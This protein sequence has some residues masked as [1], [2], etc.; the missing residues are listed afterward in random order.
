MTVLKQL[1]FLQDLRYLL[2]SWS[3]SQ[4]R[5]HAE[6]LLPVSG[7]GR[8]GGE[9]RGERCQRGPGR[10]VPQRAEERGAREGR[11]ERC[12]RGP[13]REVAK[14]AERRGGGE[15]RGE[16]CQRGPRREVTAEKLL[17]FEKEIGDGEEDGE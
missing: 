11:G 12:Q 8:G 1:K 7:I 16:R 15:S 14:R 13:R 3:V 4:S 2:Q 6:A 5:Q 9:G 17:P 10:E